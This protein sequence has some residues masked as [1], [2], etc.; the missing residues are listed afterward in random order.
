MGAGLHSVLLGRR[1]RVYGGGGYLVEFRFGDDLGAEGDLG[2]NNSLSVDHGFGGNGGG[3]EAA[4]RMLLYF[5]IGFPGSPAYIARGG[6]TRYFA[7]LSSYSLPWHL[8]QL[9]RS[10]TRL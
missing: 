6:R 3:G 2:V 8:A 5:K 10:F 7:M 4:L 1:A 9:L